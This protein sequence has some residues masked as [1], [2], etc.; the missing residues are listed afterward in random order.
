VIGS[1]CT[2]GGLFSRSRSSARGLQRTLAAIVIDDVASAEEVQNAG[3]PEVLSD[4]ELEAIGVDD[5]DYTAMESRLLAVRFE[6]PVDGA[7][8]LVVD[9]DPASVTEDYRARLLDCSRNLI[10]DLT[11]A[12]IEF[13]LGVG[14]E[15]R[16]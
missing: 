15:S 1:L 10:R 12:S 13:V 5:P 4:A 14:G 16:W 3:E 7:C 2:A 9:P 8:M 6:D 11:V